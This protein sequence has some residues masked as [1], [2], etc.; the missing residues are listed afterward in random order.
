MEVEIGKIYSN[1]QFTSC[2]SILGHTPTMGQ[3]AG[4][5]AQPFKTETTPI[6]EK[7]G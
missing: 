4:G 5:S 1:N 3:F 6:L 7:N 2:T